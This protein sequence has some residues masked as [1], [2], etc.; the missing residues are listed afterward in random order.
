MEDKHQKSYKWAHNGKQRT[1][2]Y[3]RSDRVEID[4]KALRKA[5]TAKVYD[6]FT[7]KKL[8]R[9]RMEA[10]MSAGEIDPMVVSQYITSK[11]GMPYLKYSE[12]EIEEL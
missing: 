2:T 11:P 7:V 3:V 6:K 4:E 12:K 5:L 1:V 9:K 8:D 10:A